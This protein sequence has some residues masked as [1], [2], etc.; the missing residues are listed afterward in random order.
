MVSPNAPTTTNDD[1]TT[2]VQCYT[3]HLVCVTHDDNDMKK[4]RIEDEQQQQQQQQQQQ[5]GGGGGS[6]S[7]INRYKKKKTYHIHVSKQVKKDD[8][9]F[10][11]RIKLLLILL[12][13]YNCRILQ[14]SWQHHTY[15]LK[16]ESSGGVA[17]LV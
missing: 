13:L 7:P 16:T 2:S 8:F 9:K 11:S 3:E 12:L 15:I 10:E 6:R 4:D 1:L 5:L 14:P 17:S